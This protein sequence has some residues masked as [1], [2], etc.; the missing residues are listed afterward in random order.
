M[1][2]LRQ[3][4]EDHDTPHGRAFDIAI[5]VL[6]VLSLISFTVETVEGLPEAVR[7]WL[8]WIEVVTVL[9]FTVEYILRVYVARPRRSYILSFYGVI[10][11][12]AILPFYLASGVDLR[13]VRALRLLR[14]FRLF[15]LVRYSAA[16][17]R[18]HVALSIVKEEVV[19]FLAATAILLYLAS[20]GIYFF[21]S[22]AQP[23]L[24]GSIFDSMWWAVVTLTTVGYGDVY[25]I[26]IGG[27]LF[28]FVVLLVGLGVISVPAGLVASALSKARELEKQEQEAVDAAPSEQD[29]GV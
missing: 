24:F 17:R 7:R 2:T 11:L 6:I 14:L 9:I 12:V 21:E 3:I 4:V 20:V 29:S 10:D 27:R 22:K 1:P 16:M 23:E 26:T 15:K 5:Q 25:P 19:M 28:T 13:S 18:F 8:R